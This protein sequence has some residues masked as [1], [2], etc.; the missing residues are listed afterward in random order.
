MN[1]RI[2]N[3]I[4]WMDYNFCK[5]SNI[6]LGTLSMQPMTVC[7]YFVFTYK[8]QSTSRPTELKSPLLVAWQAA[9]ALSLYL[10]EQSNTLIATTHN[11]V[12]ASEKMKTASSI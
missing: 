10:S 11:V 9:G 7:Q 2:Q 8:L 12:T 3:T 5:R 4:F 6:L 1:L